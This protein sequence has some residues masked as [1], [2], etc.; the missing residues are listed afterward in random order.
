[1]LNV[2]ISPEVA[3]PSPR[4]TGRL[5]HQGYQ[6][7]DRF[8]SAANLPYIP[9]ISNRVITTLIVRISTGQSLGI[10]KVA[11]TMDMSKRTLQ[12]HLK[13]QG[14]EYNKLRDIVRFNKSIDC[15]LVENMGIEET[16]KYLNFSDRTSFTNAFKRW[17]EKAGEKLCPSTFRKTY[18]DYI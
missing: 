6:D 12:R 3:I 2:E 7:L 5:L 11:E 10:I 17:T 18:R 16:A 15:L 4:Y 9:G 14:S 1:M 8:I 13:S